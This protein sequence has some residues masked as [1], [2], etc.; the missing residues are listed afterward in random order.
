[1]ASGASATRRSAARIAAADSGATSTWSPALQVLPLSD[2]GSVTLIKPACCGRGAGATSRRCRYRSDRGR[3]RSSRTASWRSSGA[4][5]SLR[6]CFHA[7]GAPQSLGLHGSLAAALHHD[8]SLAFASR[9]VCAL[10]KLSPSLRIVAIGRRLNSLPTTAGVSK[11][12]TSQANAPPADMFC[13]RN[14][15]AAVMTALGATGVIASGAGGVASSCGGVSHPRE[16][17]PTARRTSLTT[18]SFRWCDVWSP[19][20]SANVGA[21]RRLVGI[22]CS[23]NDS[24]RPTP[25][26]PPV[27]THS[28]PRDTSDTSQVMR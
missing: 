22:D 10:Q 5:M 7:A 18:F 26:R 8:A 21:D 28:P 13:K 1:M 11:C 15:A 4:S 23:R 6:Y 9:R 20:P 17:L 3:S 24:A 2:T 16:A 12:A 25:L 14:D 27:R 19:A